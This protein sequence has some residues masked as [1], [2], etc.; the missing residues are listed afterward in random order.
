MEMPNEDELAAL[1]VGMGVTTP[2]G[3]VFRG[4]DGELKLRLNEEG[5]MAYEEERFRK[6]STFGAYPGH[7]D[8]G[9][10]PPPLTPGM[11]SFNPFTGQW[12]E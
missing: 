12:S 11:P 8:P 5:K 3:D 7:D 9:A 1:G 6:L 2:H 4:P 10:P